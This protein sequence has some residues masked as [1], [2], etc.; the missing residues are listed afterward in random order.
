VNLACPRCRQASGSCSTRDVRRK[1][2]L[3]IKQRSCNTVIATLSARQTHS[4]IWI[5]L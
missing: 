5:L 3:Y 4:S 2:V 1:T